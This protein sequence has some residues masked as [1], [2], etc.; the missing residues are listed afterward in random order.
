MFIVHN[1]TEDALD[2][3]RD[4]FRPFYRTVI[5]KFTRQFDLDR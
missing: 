3:D 1:D 2:F 5:I 4:G